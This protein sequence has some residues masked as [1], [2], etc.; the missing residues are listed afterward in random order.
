[1]PNPPIS[2][3]RQ[4]L[5]EITD[6]DSAIS[7]LRWDQ[8]TYMPPKAAPGRGQQLATLAALHHRLFTAPEMGR[9]I[10][11]L[12]EVSDQLDPDDAKLVEVAY[13]D[14]D[15]ANKLPESFVQTFAEEQSKAFHAWV[16]AREQADF[17]MFQPH[18]ERLVELLIQKA[19]LLG[20]EESPYDALLE[21]YERGMTARQL[22]AIFGELAEKQSA[23]V[24][25][26][27][28]ARRQPDAA[29]LEQ[30]W[31]EPAQ[32]DFTLR[33]LRDMGYDLEAGRQDRSVHPFT[34]H[35]DLFDVRVTTR[36]NPKD[37]FSALMGS[38]HEGGHALY[39]QGFQEKDRR[40]PLAQG[41]S[42]GIHEAQ[43]RMWENLVGRSLPFWNYYAPLL[44]ERF[45]GQL[46]GV[47][48]EQVYAAINRVRPSFIRVEA[49]E[50]TYNLHVILRFE[51][52]FALIQG[53]ITV[54]QVPELWNAKMKQYLG[55]DVPDDAKGCLQ[56]I[57][58]S[59]GSIGYFP[60]YTLGNL[61]AAQLFEKILEDIP[62]LWSHIEQGDFTQLLGW[63]REHVHRHGRRKLAPKLVRDITGA[64]PSSKPYLDYLQNKY[65]ALYDLPD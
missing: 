51:T 9:L 47:S 3:L 34:T 58:W 33:V 35:F 36:L 55:L 42:L 38:I 2:E 14:Y 63:L 10:S 65:R 11:E 26:V 40:T 7:L 57:H 32:W 15:R 39:D 28:H 23:L 17:P 29:W 56:D 21:D 4:R 25:Q 18:L 61:Y 13:Y 37:L 62:E 19:D 53:D 50:C 64:D 5:G 46:D 43:S 31:S 45:P 16:K 1:M 20:Y 59:Y 8:E 54:A 52:E 22:R 60:T 30:D 6:V 49:D 44:R 41:V 12:R 24:D 27:V 48:P